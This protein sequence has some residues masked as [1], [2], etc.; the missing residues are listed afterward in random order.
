MDCFTFKDNLLMIVFGLASSVVLT[1]LYFVLLF[2]IRI[3]LKQRREH[4]RERQ[5]TKSRDD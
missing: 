1:T 3:D 4:I 5:R 2:A